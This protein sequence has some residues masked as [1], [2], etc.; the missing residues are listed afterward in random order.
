M[1]G[2]PLIL[3]REECAKGTG[4]RW[5]NIV[6]RGAKTLSS[7]EAF[8][9][10]MVRWFVPQKSVVT[11][12]A[13]IIPDREEFALVMARSMESTFTRGVPSI[14]LREEFVGDMVQ[15]RND[16]AMRGAKM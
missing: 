9:L 10:D 15:C 12:D 2:A 14:L 11:R 4:R 7:I 16:A 5:D 1:R 13:P 3:F 6:A 8:A